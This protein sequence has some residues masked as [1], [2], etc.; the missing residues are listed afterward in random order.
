MVSVPTASSSFSK[1]RGFA[2]WM[3]QITEAR[4]R[5]TEEVLVEWRWWRRVVDQWGHPWVGTPRRPSLRARGAFH[6]PTRCTHSATC[7]IRYLHPDPCDE[8]LSRFVFNISYVSHSEPNSSRP[9]TFT[10]GCLTCFY[11][12]MANKEKQSEYTY[13]LSKE[14]SIANIHYHTM[15]CPFP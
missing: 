10:L 12:I 2:Y 8:D 13:C 1:P 9:I 3:L 5:P 6:D 11:P 14:G 4:W 15:V 7:L